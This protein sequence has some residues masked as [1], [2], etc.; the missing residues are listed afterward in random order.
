[1]DLEEV[2]SIAANLA[3]KT[4]RRAIS[5]RHIGGGIGSGL[6][7]SIVGEIQAMEVTSGEW[8]KWQYCR[9][10]PSNGSHIS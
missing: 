3:R 9:R 2:Q 4:L 5:I 6:N 1:M 8:V 7:V 10:N